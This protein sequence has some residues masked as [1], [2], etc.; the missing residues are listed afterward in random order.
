M[1]PIL[2]IIGAQR[3]GSTS[4]A[5]AFEAS[6]AFV[7]GTEP[8]ESRLLLHS[9]DPGRRLRQIADQA[10]TSS[11][12]AWIVEKSTT[13]IEKPEAAY[14][15]SRVADAKAIAILRNPVSRA[16]S[17][18]WFTRSNGIEEL[19]IE[20]AFQSANLHREWNGAIFS[21][22]PFAYLQRSAYSTLLGPWLDALGPS[23]HILILEE[24]AESLESPSALALTDLGIDP[25]LLSIPRKNASSSYPQ[26]GEE[27]LSQLSHLLLPEIYWVEHLLQRPLPAWRSVSAQALGPY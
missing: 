11:S 15:A 10:V 7:L 19:S 5:S 26:A 12:S 2:F 8:P 24:L 18:Y 6:G 14:A 16:V 13:Y 20:A 1:R 3:S 23:L 17:N 4:L 25:Q 27:L 21:T 22:S 9:E